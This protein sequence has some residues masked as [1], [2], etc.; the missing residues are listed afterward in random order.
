MYDVLP[1]DVMQ[2]LL[3]VASCD[4]AIVLTDGR[5]AVECLGSCTSVRKVPKDNFFIYWPK[6]GVALRPLTGVTLLDPDMTI[7]RALT[8]ISRIVDVYGDVV[9]IQCSSNH[10]DQISSLFQ[11]I[12]IVTSLSKYWPKDIARIAM[13][14]PPSVSDTFDRLRRSQYGHILATTRD[15]IDVVAVAPRLSFDPKSIIEME[16]SPPSVCP[17]A[18]IRQR[19]EGQ[20]GMPKNEESARVLLTTLARGCGAVAC[21][22]A[23]IWRMITESDSNGWPW[24]PEALASLVLWGEP[25]AGGVGYRWPPHDPD[26]RVPNTVLSLDLGRMIAPHPLITGNDAVGMLPPELQRVD[27]SWKEP[28]AAPWTGGPCS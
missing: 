5:A 20:A 1:E 27:L 13:G 10:G 23:A 16:N 8:I 14:D 19:F 6:Y 22:S 3:G 2:A 25:V 24:P 18:V 7:T 17:P 28:L 12:G 9:V 11:N 4:G 21:T 26:G 15:P